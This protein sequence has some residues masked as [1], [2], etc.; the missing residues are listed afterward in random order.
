HFSPALTNPDE[1]LDSARQIFG[2]TVVA[3]DGIRAN[4]VK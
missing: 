4:I 1:Q 2:N 3:Y